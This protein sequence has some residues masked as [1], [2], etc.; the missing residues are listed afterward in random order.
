[1]S[2]AEYY[3]INLYERNDR[4]MDAK[5]IFNKYNLPVN[6]YRVHKDKEDGRRGCFTSHINIIKKAHD[7]NLDNVLIFEDDIK[8]SLDKQGFY[9]K[10]QTVYDFTNKYDYDI[11]F[12]GSIPDIYKKS[13]KKISENIYKVNAYCTHAYILSRSGINKYKNLSFDKERTSI[14]YIYRESDKSYAIYPSIFFQN[15]SK[16]DIAPSWFSFFGSKEIIAKLRE[17][18]AAHI[19]IPLVLHFQIIIIGSA[20]LYMITGK[21]IFLLIPI[22]YICYQIFKY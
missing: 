6:F 20:L 18:Y 8:C 5:Q 16:S 21:M 3:C 4:M 7:K 2:I 13:T 22:I 15:E 17:Q 9:K 14:D 10:M 19:N 12:L 1:M 11:F